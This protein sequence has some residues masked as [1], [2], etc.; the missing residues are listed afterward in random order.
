VPTDECSVVHRAV[1]QKSPAGVDL[2][3]TEGHGFVK[4]TYVRCSDVPAL[5]PVIRSTDQEC[6]SAATR[7][8]RRHA[9]QSGIS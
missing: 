2:S 5:L 4:V 7:G 1:S 8:P 6:L 3:Q 9:G